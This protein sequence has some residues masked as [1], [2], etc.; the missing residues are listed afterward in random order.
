MWP[1]FKV[2]RPIARKSYDCD[3]C[4]HYLSRLHPDYFEPDDYFYFSQVQGR[5]GKILKGERY[6][7]ITWKEDGV[8][9]VFRAIPETDSLCQKYDLYDYR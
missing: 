9:K 7:K 6:I 4:K 8:F 2:S 3:A 5:G 1:L